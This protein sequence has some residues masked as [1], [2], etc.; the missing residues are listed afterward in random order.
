[1]QRGP[2]PQRAVEL[3]KPKDSAVT[4]TDEDKPAMN[5]LGLEEG[6]MELWDSP[7]AEDTE[8]GSRVLFPTF[9]RRWQDAAPRHQ[10]CGLYNPRS[11]QPTD[12]LSPAMS[13]SPPTLLSWGWGG[14]CR[15]PRP[16]LPAPPECVS[17][18]LFHT[19]GVFKTCGI[20]LQVSAS[21]FIAATVMSTTEEPINN[22][23]VPHAG[24]FMGPTLFDLLICKIFYRTTQLSLTAG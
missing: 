5:E 4:R 21:T 14:P 17:P 19:R 20:S 13:P 2:K 23:N 12:P 3:F 9:P 16:C 8:N 15:T 10:G 24:P 11:P 22:M 18:A 1:M 6:S 7:G